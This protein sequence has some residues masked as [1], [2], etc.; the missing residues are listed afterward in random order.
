[1]KV[2]IHWLKDYVDFDI[3]VDELAH[4]L[5]MVGLEVEE[6]LRPSQTFRGVVV[7][8]ID[9]VKN[10]PSADKLKVCTVDIGNEILTIVYT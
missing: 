2:N 8:R 3:S 4:R 5:T 10:H 1:M 9:E 7:G 6:I